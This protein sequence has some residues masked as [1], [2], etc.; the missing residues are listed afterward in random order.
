L[1]FKLLFWF[2]ESRTAKLD[3]LAWQALPTQPW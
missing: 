1:L 2:G 3:R